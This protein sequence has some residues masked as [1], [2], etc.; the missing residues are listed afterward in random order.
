M[1]KLTEQ[2]FYYAVGPQDES[3]SLE[4]YERLAMAFI[5]LHWF[6][7]GISLI[8]LFFNWSAGQM[9]PYLLYGLLFHSN[10]V[11]FILAILSWCPSGNKNETI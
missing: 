8:G 3:E 6:S 2:L 10:V 9:H 5:Y 11:L 4:T 1:K 7:A